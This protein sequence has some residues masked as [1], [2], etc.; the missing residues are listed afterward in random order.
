M[1]VAVIYSACVIMDA[2]PFSNI[3][4]WKKTEKNKG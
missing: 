3:V 2:V 4:L 1:K